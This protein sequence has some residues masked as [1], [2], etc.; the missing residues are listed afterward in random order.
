LLTEAIGQEHH[1][2]CGMRDPRIVI[3]GAGP[4][5]GACGIAF[6][7]LGMKDIRLLDKSSYPRGKACG[8]GLSPLAIEMLGRLDVTGRFAKRAEIRALQAKGPGGSTTRLQA[9]GGAWVVPRSRLD[10]GLA[11]AAEEGGARFEPGTKVVSLLR[12][13][14]GRICGVRTECGEIEADLVVCADGGV[15][16]FS[17]DRSRR[18]TIVTIMGWWAGTTLPSDEAVMV[19]DRRLEGYYAWSFPEPGGLVNIGLTLPSWSPRA[20][21]LR[22]LFQEILD[23]HFAGDLRGAELCGK[24]IGLPAV[25]TGRVGPIAESNGL[26]IGEAARLVMPGT[27]EGIGF[28]LESGICAARFVERHFQAGSGFSR[29]AVLGYRLSTARR[30]LPKFWAGALFV[31]LVQSPRV[32]SLAQRLW[33]GSLQKV[34]GNTVA[35]LVG[36]DLRSTP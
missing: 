5:G 15:S 10:H 4:A 13:P 20:H 1:S 14:R 6:A 11:L 7:K 32:L 23:E 19:W 12:D 16:R 28:A 25:V 36:D 33:T 18:S 35:R 29:P 26:W 27:V 30:V 31:K 2:A 24:W 22:E 3:V 21:D 9:G 34:I 17:P 8:S